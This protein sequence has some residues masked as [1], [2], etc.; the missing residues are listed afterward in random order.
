MF[1][2]VGREIRIWAKVLV[3]LQMIPV[4]IGA[5]AVAFAM[6]SQDPDLTVPAIL[7]GIIIL[8]VGFFI[9][10]LGGLLLY[11]WGEMVVRVSAID[12]KLNRMNPPM[13]YMPDPYAPAPYSTPAPPPTYPPIK[14]TIAEQKAEQQGCST[15][16]QPIP[17]E[18]EEWY[19]AV[20]GKKNAPEGRWCENCGTKREI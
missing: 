13:P 3:I 5:I 16:V 12:D 6:I 14:P 10:R 18:P 4:A 9:A 7:V 20:C 19:C 15:P 17:R 2:N 8:V 11:S 1:K